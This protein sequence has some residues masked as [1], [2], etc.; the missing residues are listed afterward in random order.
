MFRR[1]PGRVFISWSGPTSKSIARALKEAIESAFS[2]DEVTV[3]FSDR[4][5]SAGSEW[6]QSIKNEL[7]E[8]SVGILC[9]TPENIDAPWIYF[10]AGAM[11][12]RY[13]QP[14]VVPLLINVELPE[15]SPLRQLHC[16]S[17]DEEGMISLLETISA[18][19]HVPR[20]SPKYLRCLSSGAFEGVRRCAGESLRNAGQRL[21][22]LKENIYPKGG[23]FIKRKSVFLSSPMTSVESE[24][25]YIELQKSIASLINELEKIGYEVFYGG[26]NVQHM[27]EVNQAA[28]IPPENF[29]ALKHAE[30]VILLHPK[31]LATSALIEVGYALALG[32][33]IVI[34]AKEG[35]RLPLV[36]SGLSVPL[37]NVR[38]YVVPGMDAVAKL[39]EKNGAFALEGGR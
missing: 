1:K 4:D 11:A 21:P 38:K 32:K 19:C 3:F 14:A 20:R 13:N 23:Y 25:E 29:R 2:R 36:L 34:F 10:E 39:I 31:Y 17:F 26:V 24:D 37:P 27:S 16:R 12:M 28:R 8:S 30:Y 7:R 22:L 5:L 35:E 15:K 18:R 6:Y 33:E 9:L